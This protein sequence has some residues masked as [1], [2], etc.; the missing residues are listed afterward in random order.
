MSN[1][2]QRLVFLIFTIFNLEADRVACL[3]LTNVLITYYAHEK[4]KEGKGLR[5][6][7]PF[8]DETISGDLRDLRANLCNL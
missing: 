1:K 7:R 8:P 6:I 2:L 5:A 3:L 4:G